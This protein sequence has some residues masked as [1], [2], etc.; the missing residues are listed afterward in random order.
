[1][2]VQFS[3]L[4]LLLSSSLASSRL[5]K[6]HGIPWCP[7]LARRPRRAVPAPKSQPHSLRGFSF[8]HPTPFPQGIRT[9]GIA[10]P[11][12]QQ[13]PLLFLGPGV[14]YFHLNAF[15]S[16]IRSL[17]GPLGAGVTAVAAAPGGLAR[18]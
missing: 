9:P 6:Q 8:P 16:I 11:A 7:P 3:A 10:A 18:H 17:L 2:T 15:L 12:A 5:W 4:N 14:L 1:M 13:L